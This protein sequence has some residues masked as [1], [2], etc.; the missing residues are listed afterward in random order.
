MDYTRVTV[1]GGSGFLGSYIVRHLA[2]HGT[3]VRVAARHRRDTAFPQP[4]DDGSITSVHADVRD[5]ISVSQAVESAEAVVNAVG[6]YVERGSA[7]FDAVHVQGALNVA[8]QAS[9]AGV[10][11]L[12]HISGIGADQNSESRYVRARAK[13]ESLIRE[14]FEGATILRPSVLFGREDAFLN[15]L[16]RLARFSPVLPLFGNGATLLQPV[17]VGNVAEAVRN[18]LAE[19]TSRGKVYELGGP[20]VYSYKELIE[21]L[22][23]RLGRQRILVPVP[24]FLWELQAALLSVLPNPPLTHDQIVLMKQD[25]VVRKGALTLADL[26]IDPTAVETLLPT[27]R[28]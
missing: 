7:T 24:Y 11:R 25:N 2:A 5:E 13:G 27:Y 8:R 23:K 21:L 20:R 4:P 15:T 22:V 10:A 18:V 6:L 28:F 9:R 19:P 1:F 16:A 12:L 17:F 14:A 26:G 3:K